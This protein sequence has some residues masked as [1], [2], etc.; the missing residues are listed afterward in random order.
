MPSLAHWDLR[1]VNSLHH[2]PD[3]TQATGFGREDGMVHHLRERIKGEEMLFIFHQAAYR[4][5]I[6]LLVFALEGCELGQGFCLR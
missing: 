1:Q 6:A 5:G 2:G 3:D 4:F